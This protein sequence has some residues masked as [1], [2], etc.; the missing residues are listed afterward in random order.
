MKT[1]AFFLVAALAA[2]AVAA[3]QEATGPQ[4]RER[5]DFGLELKRLDL[6]G[7]ERGR[8][9]G[10]LDAEL[11]REDRMALW[12]SPMDRLMI[13][14]AREQWAMRNPGPV[15]IVIPY[16]ATSLPVA[17]RVAPRGELLL[18]GPWSRQW[19]RLTWQEKVAADAQTGLFAWTLI[20][21]MRHAF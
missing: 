13:G 9:A 12:G 19:E 20:E 7:D 15:G 1:T 18:L 16:Q 2:T 5:R 17:F 10:L 11:A 14:V 6:A 21:A 8:E 3:G 4:A